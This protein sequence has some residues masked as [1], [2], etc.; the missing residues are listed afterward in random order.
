M[1][2]VLLV[3]DQ[4]QN[5]VALEAVLEPLELDLVSVTSGEAALKQL[6][7]RTF[8]LILLD[9]QM[10]GLDGFET[11]RMIKERARSSRIPIIFL[12]ALNK[13]LT[14]VHRGYSAGAVDYLFKPFDPEILRSKVEVFI[15]LHRKTAALA[16]NEE[17][18]RR[19]VFELAR[20]TEELQR[21]NEDLQR[22]AY[23]AAH[24]LSEPLR[25]IS[26]L[27]QQLQ[28]HHDAGLDPSG[29]E[30]VGRIVSG[31]D[32][33]QGLIDD[34]LSYAR[35]GQQEAV[36]RSVDTKAVVA[37][38]LEHMDG[39]LKE[40]DAT[41]EI[42]DLPTVEGDPRLLEQVFQ[43]LIGNAVKFAEAP[44]VSVEAEREFD[45]WRFTV[46]DNGPGFNAEQA[47]RM[48][49]VFQRLHEGPD[50]PGNGIGLAICKRIV[51]RQG[52]RIWATPREPQGACFSFTVPDPG[53]R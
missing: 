29:R 41:I 25:T 32:R 2:S 11:A 36:R 31:A 21:S 43:N 30:F 48:F 1:T 12:T 51:E 45:G 15:E 3:D 40:R 53:T 7:D 39:L 16:E 46:L 17:H 44:E 37:H 42:G 5:L 4:R 49:E 23:A 35:V 50:Y 33:L 9:V 19:A 27:A 10:P 8:A 13:E 52:G 34:L 26:G 38:V 20:R 6:L 14:H 24:D 47:D 28:S 22:F 18:L